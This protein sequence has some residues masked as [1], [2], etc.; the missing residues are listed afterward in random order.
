MA[1]YNDQ[2]PL[3][4]QLL[5]LGLEARD[6]IERS[7]YTYQIEGHNTNYAM[8]YFCLAPADATPYTMDIMEAIE[9]TMDDL[10][11]FASP[12]DVREIMGLVQ[13]DELDEGTQAQF[14]ND[15][16]DV[17]FIDHGWCLD[18]QL[19]SFD[20]IPPEASDAHAILSNE[21][22][23]LIGDCFDTQPTDDCLCKAEA[24]ANDPSHRQTA[25]HDRNPLHDL[26]TGGWRVHL[27]QE[28]EHYGVNDSLIYGDTIGNGVPHIGERINDCQLYGH[29]LPLVEFYDMTKNTEQDG[30]F[31]SRYYMS[32]LL[33]MDESDIPL[34]DMK[35]FSL[36]GGV[37]AWTVAGT[38]LQNV[39]D[40]LN[41]AK[42]TLQPSTGEESAPAPGLGEPSAYDYQLL[43]RLKSDCD[44]YLGACVDFGMDMTAAQKNLWA[45]NIEAQVAKM[46]ELYDKLP[47]KPDWLTVQDIDRYE[48]DMLAQRDPAPEQ[49]HGVSL[50]AEAKSARDSSHALDSHAS[51]APIHETQR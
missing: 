7:I 47:E 2:I 40:W 5:R 51:D 11:T 31:V 6:G 21:Q 34:S 46:R 38:D 27:V 45:G 8:P 24:I 29:G 13:G 44:Y 39:T 12:D 25:Y 30:Q 1:E 48:H 16:T 4:L 26:I 20:K 32:T 33:G 49:E 36:D 3:K 15:E 42:E 10:L 18:G 28:G 9:Q 43:D 22:I 14:E 37:P 41:T 17:T 23:A 35:A 50:T 19:L